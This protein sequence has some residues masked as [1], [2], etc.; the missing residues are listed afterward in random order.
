MGRVATSR[1]RTSKNKCYK[2]QHDTKRRRRD[3]DQIQDDIV[4]VVANG[5]SNIEFQLDEDLPGL[6]QH[7]CLT[8]ARHF[9]NDITLK[10][11]MQTKAHKRR[12][13]LESI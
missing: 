12:F 3:I 2:K 9:S 5:K 8:C 13:H 4:K 10:S 11:H 1:R 6:G 7:Y